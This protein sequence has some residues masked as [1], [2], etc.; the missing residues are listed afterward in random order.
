[1]KIKNYLGLTLGICLLLTAGCKKEVHPI[2]KP[3]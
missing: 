2:T 1:M 3:F